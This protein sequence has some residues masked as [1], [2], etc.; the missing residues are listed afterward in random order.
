M[1]IDFPFH[2]SNCIL[3][4]DGCLQ[5]SRYRIA[6]LCGGGK[7]WRIGLSPRIGGEIFGKFGFPS[8]NTK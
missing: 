2:M 3:M 6:Q 7:Y 5:S 8:Y 4:W 1:V